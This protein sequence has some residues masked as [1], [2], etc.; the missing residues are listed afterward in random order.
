MFKKE[1][2]LSLTKLFLRLSIALIFSLGLISSPN[3]TILAS[4]TINV[5]DYIKD[6]FPSVIYNIYLAS[7]N[8]LDQHEKEFIDILQNLPEDRQR[9]YAKEI[10]NNGFTQELLEKVRE[11]I[12]TE[13]SLTKFEEKISE[14]LPSISEEI[15]PLSTGIV[16]LSLKEKIA[17][18]F[19]LNEKNTYKHWYNRFL[20]CGVDLE[21]SRRVV[22]RIKNFYHWCDEWSKEGENLE[23]LAQEAL[24]AENTYTAKYLFHEAAGCFFVGQLPYYI[25][26]RKKNEAQERARENYKRAIEL[27]GEG[28][29]PI[30][31]EIPFRETF[32]PGYLKLCSHPNRPLII[33][34]NSIDSIKEI[35]N[36]YLGNL[37][38][39]AGF[40]V[41]AFD[42]PGQGEMWK[43]MKMIPDYEKTI[44]TII[45]WFEE[46]NKYN[47]DF[48]KIATY[49]IS[50]GGYFSFRAAAFDKR[51]CCAVVISA[52]GYSPGFSE[53]KK[54][55]RALL[56]TTGANSL[57][58]VTS[59]W[60]EIS[61][62]EVP[63]LDR[64]IL[65]IYGE[66]DKLFPL[67]HAY[68]LMDWAIGEKELK[69]YSEGK[70]A[71]SN[72]LDEA[73][74][75]SIDWLRKYLLE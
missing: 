40:N 31:I 24:S 73:V 20:F 65:L 36:H 47:I 25:D 8:G 46:N 53:L 18:R 66:E 30:R 50:L 43:N 63:Q 10:Y 75:C 71:C 27:L 70:H 11:E 62:K 13:K 16:K 56:Y 22:S 45:N 38:L 74:P 19:I 37:L 42:G 28:K 3:S 49:G 41:F 67:E 9:Y 39:E 59:L 26:I 17:Y 4:E 64:P 12:I 57:K 51:I 58:E 7:L 29:R 15:E 69:S 33:I 14:K 44:S 2:R 34:I 60:G 23:T 52:P 35:E 54:V 21:R 55:K 61:I 48:K 1:K 68:C 6:K 72:F 5:K 32:I